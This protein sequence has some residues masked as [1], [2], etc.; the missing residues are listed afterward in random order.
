MQV[1]QVLPD[2]LT[3]ARSCLRWPNMLGPVVPFVS[4]P[5]WVTQLCASGIDCG[6]WQCVPLGLI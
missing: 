1:L 3:V 4:F 5:L 6:L 2:V